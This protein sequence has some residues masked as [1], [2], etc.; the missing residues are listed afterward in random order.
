[1]RWLFVLALLIAT[2]RPSHAAELTPITIV[3]GSL[4]FNFVPLAVARAEGYFTDEGLKVD[5]VLAGGG[6]KA[7]TALLGGGG[8]F[9][10]SVLVDGIMAHRK[11][12]DDVRAMAKLSGFFNGIVIRDDVAKARGISLDLPLKERVALMKGL[13]MGI[14]TPGASSDLVIRYLALS[15]GLS[16]DRDL[17]I[18]PLGGVPTGIAGVQAGQVDGCACVPGA[19]IVLKQMGIA[20]DLVRPGEMIDLEG[21]AYGTFY[22]LDSYNKAHPEVVRGVAR[23]IARAEI[24]IGNDPARASRDTRPTMKEMDDPTFAAA[25]QV[26]L[27]FIATDPDI[28]E[29][30]FARELAFEKAVLPPNVYKPV[31]YAET[32]DATYV[33]AAMRELRP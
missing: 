29:T 18:V 32:V 22:G 20:R 6:P 5:V 28:T 19:D 27:A 15:N 21:I 23:A 3:Q 8:Q 31:P 33:R 30:D 4:G 17:Q 7:M 12:L 25:W 11:G 1:M 24:L 2:V 10:A 26:Y 16:P 14:T 13:R 9:S